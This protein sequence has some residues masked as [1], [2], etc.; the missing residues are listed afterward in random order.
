MPVRRTFFDLAN[1]LTLS[2]IPLA[3]LIWLAPRRSP[4]RE[5]T[6]LSLMAVAALT[7]ML[8]GWFARQSKTHVHGSGEWL[9]PLCDKIFLLSIL[10]S[11]SLVRR[12]PWVIPVMIASREII[13]VVVGGP[14]LLHRTSKNASFF[15]AGVDFRSAWI[16]KVTTASQFLAIWAWWMGSPWAIPLSGVSALLGIQASFYYIDRMIKPGVKR[17]KLTV[18]RGATSTGSSRRKNG[19]I[20]PKLGE[21]A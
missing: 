13:Q 21:I 14:K 19:F 12:P 16:G 3:S 8:D 6:A 18:E 4:Q 10:A 1:L 5:W 9:D 15:R 17:E 20:Q 7:D 11:V 2:R